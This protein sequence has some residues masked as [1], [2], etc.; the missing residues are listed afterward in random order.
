[1]FRQ[2]TN[3]NTATNIQVN[4][5]GS[6]TADTNHKMEERSPTSNIL[7]L[8]NLQHG[9]NYWILDLGAT[10]HVCSSL[11]EFTLYKSIK[12]IPISLP[13]GHHVFAKYFGTVIF[14]HKFYLIDVLCV[15]QLSFNLVS[16]SKLSLNMNCSLIFSSNNCMIQDN[17]TKEMIVIVSV[18]VGLYAFESS[19][20]RNTATHTIALSFNCTVKDINLWHYRMG[21]LSDER[22]NVVRTKYSYIPAKKP[23]LCDVCHH[24]KQKKLPFT[25]SRS[26]TTNIFE[27]LH[28]DI[29]GPYS[30]ISMHGFRYFLN[31]VDDFSRFT[32]V[33]SL[34]TKSEVRNHIVNFIAYI[35]NQ[36]KTTV[37]TIR[38]DN[39]AE[40]AMNFFFS[41]GIVHQTTYVETPEQNEIVERKHQHILNVTRTLLFQA[42]LPHSGI[43]LY[44][45]L[46]F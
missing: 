25:L 9:R 31:I 12:P 34:H 5:V 26:H 23:H 4:Q 33:I 20:F 10:D 3:N 17:T 29:W 22:L 8:N 46:F 44:K 41:K 19:F 14:N 38:T 13:N 2:S 30:V 1:L 42:N 37:K 28:M 16:T 15:P 39:G 24:V 36:F 21:H 7:T 6:F 35:E 27:L 40:F 11:S 32:W 43:L 45:M 18:K